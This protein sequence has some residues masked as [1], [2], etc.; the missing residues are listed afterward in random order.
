LDVN[1]DN[2]WVA[3]GHFRSGLHLS[4]GTAMVMSQLIRG[5]APQADLGPFGVGR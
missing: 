1:V 2:V 3:A 5:Q 4:T